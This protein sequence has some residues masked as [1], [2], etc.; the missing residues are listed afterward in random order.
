MKQRVLVCGGRDYACREQLFAVLDQAH[1]ANPIEVV[2][3]GGARG[4]DALAAEWATVRVVAQQMFR[5]KWDELGKRAGP[6]RNKQMLAEGSP[7]VV[8]AFAGG[9]GTAD[10]VRISRNAGVPVVTVRAPT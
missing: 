5:A 3:H 7:D 10:M 2:I 4:A 1:G 6:I 9:R 8:I